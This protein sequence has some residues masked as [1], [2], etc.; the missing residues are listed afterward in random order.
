[1]GASLNLLE[2]ESPLQ[3]VHPPFDDRLLIAIE[4]AL[5]TAWAEILQDGT[6]LEVLEKGKETKI[7]NIL[8][9]RLERIRV[10]ENDPLEY[11]CNVFERPHVSAEYS[12]YKKERPE[13]PD[14][15]FHLSGRPRPGV[16]DSLYDGLYVE[17]KILD[18]GSRN[19]GRYCRN[20]VRRFVDGDYGWR[21]SQGMMC[22]YVRTTQELPVALEGY[23]RA[24][25][26][27]T[28]LCLVSTSLTKSTL[29]E[30]NPAIYLSDHARP[31]T[32]PDGSSP[33]K[34]SLQHL[35]LQAGRQS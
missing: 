7:T 31:W 14:L 21:M 35:W 13:L 24:S 27:A 3:Q 20:G 28:T 25:R 18:N 10:R 33:G 6:V 15:V 11:N 22:A 9:E 4:I 30:Y 1:M 19:L 5:R 26:V 17:C 2:P 16:M 12:N 34:I 32:F 8:R 29:T 23:F